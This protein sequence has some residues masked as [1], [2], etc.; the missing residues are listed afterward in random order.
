MVSVESGGVLEAPG[1]VV[2]DVC[3]ADEDV[4]EGEEGDAEEDGEVD[5]AARISGS[6]LV[7]NGAGA[8]FHR[9]H[10]VH[11]LSEMRKRTTLS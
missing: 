2:V 4:D 7:N 3:G 11:S 8:L 5:D 1:G 6:L 10:R 9:T